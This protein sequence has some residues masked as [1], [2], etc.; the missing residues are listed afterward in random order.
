MRPGPFSLSTCSVGREWAGISV[1]AAHAVIMNDFIKPSRASRKLPIPMALGYL[2]PTVIAL[3]LAGLTL[4]AQADSGT[5]PP[6]STPAD[7]PAS[8][9]D[10]P[11]ETFQV[12]GQF[13]NVAQRHPAFRSPYQ[14]ANSLPP[15]EPTMETADITLFV[16]LRLGQHTELYVNPEIDQG[17]GLANTLGVAG[18]PSGEAYKVGTWTPYYRTPRAFIRQTW[19]LPGTRSPVASDANTLAGLRPDN[20]LTLTV[21][22]FS[23]VDIFDANAYAHDPRGDFLNWSIVDSG[24]FDYAADSWGFTLGAAL[25]WN[26]GD[27][28]LRGGYF[29]LSTS[30]N[31]ET[32]D[33]TFAQHSWVLEAERRF[34]A[35]GH[36]GRVRALAFVD[37]A[38][39]G[40]YDE[41]VALALGSGSTPDTAL[42]RRTGNKAGYGVNLEQAVTDDVGVFAR[43]SANNGRFETF[44]FTDINRS[45]SAG[46]SVRGARW[47]RAQDTVGIAGAF[48]ALSS[49]ARAYFAA[50]GM[51]PL[52]GDGQ[53]PH[54]AQ[55]RILEGYYAMQ[56]TPA[57]TIAADVQSIANPAYNADRGP[58]RVYGTRLHTQF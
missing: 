17:F 46:L 7:P 35:L 48:N 43:L 42:V 45:A 20:N 34:N 6:S 47:G 23:V 54:Y 40:R 55:E 28:S 50:G 56:V 44:D 31:S 13:T 51:G 9:P 24:A 36:P 14:G 8:Q 16:G 58:V 11:A 32:L 15:V 38:R 49:A 25:E 57:L 12:H 27:W 30:P 26:Q 37:H 18:Y 1:C 2:K 39:I 33:T 3:A 29:A 22:K 5:T 41:A 19:A 10:A 53:L 21:G 4:A 52:I